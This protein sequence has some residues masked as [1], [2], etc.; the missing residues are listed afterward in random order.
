MYPFS[1]VSTSTGTFTSESDRSAFIRCEDAEEVIANL[2]FR[3]FRP[4]ITSYT[5]PLMTTHGRGQEKVV[6]GAW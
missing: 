5:Y 6:W 2:V 1:T 4:P 3:P